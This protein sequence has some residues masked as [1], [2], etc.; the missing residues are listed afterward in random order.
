MRENM[1][2][3]VEMREREEEGRIR[4]KEFES[5]FFNKKEREG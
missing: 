3:D 2:G 5:G 4:L 1:R